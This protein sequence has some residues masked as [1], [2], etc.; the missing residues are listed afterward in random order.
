MGPEQFQR[1]VQ[2]T[3]F[4]PEVVYDMNDRQ[5]SALCYGLGLSDECGEVSG[6][7]K[8]EI[9]HGHEMNLDELVKELGDV[10]WYLTAI[11]LH[12]GIRL[13]EVMLA[14][15]IKLAKRYP[16]G[17]SKQDSIARVDIKREDVVGEG[18]DR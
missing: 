14:N 4:G 8:K 18:H 2:R 9:F 11:A 13:E 16:N 7:I 15:S 10:L 6:M 5:K 17:F 1:N 3:S 12:Y